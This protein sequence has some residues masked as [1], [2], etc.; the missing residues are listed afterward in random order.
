MLLALTLNYSNFVVTS[1]ILFPKFIELACTLVKDYF[2]FYIFSM[3]GLTPLKNDILSDEI[4]PPL[5]ES[6]YLCV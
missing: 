6:K 5:I 1:I 2:I 4:L 3:V